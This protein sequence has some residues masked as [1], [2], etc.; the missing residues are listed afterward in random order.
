MSD[1]VQRERDWLLERLRGA[2][3]EPPSVAE[4]R[5]ER[6]GNDPTPL[7]RILERERFVV[8]VEGDRF[9][10]TESVRDLVERL[11]RKMEPGRAYGPAELREIVGTS[12]KYLIP[13]LEYCDRQRVTERRSEGRVLGE[14]VPG[15][16]A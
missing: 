8:A 14:G 9:Y 12:R 10:S 3:A 7:L 1:S 2:G 4:L 6:G 15:G 16:V 11:H 5:S 13:F